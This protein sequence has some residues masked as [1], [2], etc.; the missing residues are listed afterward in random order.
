[1][2]H[3]E[4]NATEV[5]LFAPGG[6]IHP[7]EMMYAV[8]RGLVRI[9]RSGQALAVLSA[10]SIFGEMT[11]IDKA[12]TAVA[13]TECVLIPL[14]R[15]HVHETPALTTQVLQSLSEGLRAAENRLTH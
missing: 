9:E 15:P 4:K 2:I 6:V 12:V 3:A 7:G 5:R 8:Q 10:G 14:D 11:L 13:V 1:M